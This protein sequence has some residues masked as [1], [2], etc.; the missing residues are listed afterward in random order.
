MLSC[1]GAA[2]INCVDVGQQS[3]Q[4]ELVW[5][6]IAWASEEAL[7]IKSGPIG[8]MIIGKDETYLFHKQVDI[9]IF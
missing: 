1:K 7:R 6:V 4:I 9:S 3:W 2:I 8:S 5:I